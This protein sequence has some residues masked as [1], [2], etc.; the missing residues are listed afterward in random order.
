MPRKRGRKSRNA[1]GSN[2]DAGAGRR[3]LRFWADL[4]D[5]KGY[6]RH[7][8]TIVGTK[9]DGDLELARI[10]LEHA[11]DRPVPTL[12]QAF[13]AWW[14]PDA[15]DRLERGEMARSTYD[16]YLSRWRRHVEPVWG[17]VTVTGIRAIDVQEW[18]M[19]MTS[20]MASMSLMLMRQVLDLCQRYEAVES[21]VAAQRYRM[22]RKSEREHSKDVYNL[23]E[24]VA[25]LDAVRGTAAY[26][27][28]VLCG[29]ASCRVGESLGPRVDL[30]EVRPL[31]AGG[32]TVAVVDIIRNVDR[33]GHPGRDHDLKN[34]QSE[35]PVIVPAPWSADVLASEGPW[36]TDR[37][38]A[39]PY[40]QTIVNRAWDDALNKAGIKSIPFR[41]L[42]SSWRTIMRWELGVDEDKVEAMMGHAG[43][44]VG[45]VHYDRPREEVFAQTVAEAWVRYRAS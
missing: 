29:L 34:R 13:E 9:R 44:N 30:G 7:S 33:N 20:T 12:G 17:D 18:L 32:M 41:N 39:S 45:E 38:D 14:L 21:N 5:G 2:D 43:K 24:M 16:N 36:L 19:T 27:P 35:R 25:A 26:V 37:G 22:P 4:H 8:K 10:R 11:E 40:S 31:E 23:S 3:R 15:T 42:R 1:W 28:A 6:A